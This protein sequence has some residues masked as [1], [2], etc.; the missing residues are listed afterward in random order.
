MDSFL[1]RFYISIATGLGIG[2][3]PVA[4]GTFGSLEALLLVWFLFPYGPMVQLILIVSTFLLGA[5]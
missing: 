4:P 5:Y 3:L 2:F 1:N